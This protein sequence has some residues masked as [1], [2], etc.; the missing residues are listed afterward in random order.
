ML[1]SM[2]GYGR[3]CYQ[4]DE[5]IIL[6]EIKTVNHKYNDISIKIPREIGFLEETIKSNIK[7]K[8]TRGKIDVY[9]SYNNIS[10]CNK[11]VIINDKLAQKYIM[12]L[13]NTA[14]DLEL[15][16]TISISDIAR[17]PD[18][19]TII[20]SQNEEKIKQELQYALDEAI[21]NLEK[22]RTKEGEKLA[23]DLLARIEVVKEN[24]QIISRFSTGLVDKYVV[25]LKERIME[26]TKDIIIDENRIAM[27]AVIF[28]D[29]C[30]IEEEL[31]RLNS[32]ICQ[33]KEMINDDK[34]VGKKMDFLVQE[35][36]RE[37][38]TI[39]SKANCLDITKIVVNL[40][41]ELENIREQIQNIE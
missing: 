39:A 21:L 41:N 40:K 37:T 30:S 2:T 4:S 15:E 9:V 12:A 3:G 11:E 26:M 31:T 7:K 10:N 32:H 38:N 29:K 27:E 13:K 33:F 8:I 24:V 22:M 35:M 23:A 28:A 1:K 18:V 6:I 20:D 25:K 19:I 17:I 16:P 5:N 36:N 14:K 34:S